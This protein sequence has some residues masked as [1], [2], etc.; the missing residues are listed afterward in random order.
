MA[1]TLTNL[2]PDIYEALDVVSREV[3]G[4]IPA[5]SRDSTL[6]RL[7]I[8]E[9]ARVPVASDATPADNTPAVNAP[10]TGDE[11]IDNVPV[12]ISKSRHVPVR[13]SGEETKGLMNAGTF[14][15][16][17]ADRFYQAMRALV[18]EIESDLYTEAYQSAS[19]AYGTAGTTPFATAGDMTD[20]S[21]VLRILE[22]NGAPRNDLQ[23]A[24]GHAAMGNLRG[25]QANLFKVNE[26]GSSDML[27]NGMTDRIM[28]MAIRHSDPIGVHTKGT[29]AGYLLSAAGAVGDT[30]LSVDTGTGTVVAGD[31]VTIAGTTDKYVVNTALSGGSFSIGK[32]GLL[33][34]EAD[35]DAVTIGNNYTPNV[36]FARS[37]IVLATRAPA[38]P[39]GGD[40]AVDRVEVV[41]PVTGLAFEIATYAQFRQIVH[42]VSLAWGFKAIKENHIALLMG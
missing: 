42:H 16:I 18:N 3:T 36:A 32:P 33:A 19:R 14:S 4:F 29:G 21:G 37:A 40:A 15:S 17:Q 1:N 41:D 2:L 13:W 5:V 25:K 7:A 10:D 31:I 30:S 8:G 28:N 35:N 9:T 38:L 6:E 20:F 34:A 23:L 24:L 26:A 12:T 11:T 27:R 39:E 22:E